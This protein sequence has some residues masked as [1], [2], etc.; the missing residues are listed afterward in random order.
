MDYRSIAIQAFH[1]IQ[2]S[3][4]LGKLTDYIPA[5]ASADINTYGF[6]MRTNDGSQFTLGD[7]EKW[8]TIQSISKLLTLVLCLDKDDSILLNS[9]VGIAPS[10]NGFNSLIQLEYENGIPRNPFINA[11]ALVITYSL[12]SNYAN[13]EFEILNLA[14]QLSGNSTLDYNYEVRIGKGNRF[15]KC[16][17]G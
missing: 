13:P 15:P 4:G 5:L 11:G 8:F 1:K 10:G 12:I 9:R 3:V 16:C 6:A 14:R 17:T 7:A 2:S